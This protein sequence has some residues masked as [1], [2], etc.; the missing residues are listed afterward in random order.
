MAVNSFL[1]RIAPLVLLLLA[2][3]C[4][5]DAPRDNPFD[6]NSDLYDTAASLE[7][8]IIRKIPPYNG[9]PD[10]EIRLSGSASRY[11]YTNNDGF[12]SFR[13]LPGDSVQIRVHKDGYGSRHTHVSL[14]DQHVEIL[15]NGRP[16]TDSL[17][18]RTTHRSHWWPVEDEYMLHIEAW[19]SDIDGMNDIDSVWFSIPGDTTAL[20]TEPPYTDQGSV[21]GELYDW[22]LSFP[23][24]D[25]A[26]RVFLCHIRDRDSLHAEPAGASISRFI[27][28]SPSPLAP[29]GDAEAG[30]LP[31]L[32]WDYFDASYTF[33]YIVEIFRI[34]SG[35]TAVRVFNREEI[36][37]SVTELTVEDS[38]PPGS[39][40]WTLGVVDRFGNSSYSREATFSVPE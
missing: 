34:T 5:R 7:G 30:P 28:N 1:M 21:S 23:I 32:R 17:H 8:Q 37:Q 22:E 26:G 10:V 33:Y 25:L 3:G 6:P 18:I 20:G 16:R 38:L 11:T 12:F 4:T 39:Y 31:T 40:Y 27:E 35:N 2:I 14:P 13:H 29:V 24:T 9:I 15:L 19:I 36:A